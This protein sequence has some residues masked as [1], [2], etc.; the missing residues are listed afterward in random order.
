M[1][2]L[3]PN[4][5]NDKAKEQIKKAAFCRTT[6]NAKHTHTQL[7]IKKIDLKKRDL[8]TLIGCFMWSDVL[9]AHRISDIS[10]QASDRNNNDD[11]NNATK[12]H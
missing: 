10:K 5:D 8:F 6:K 7:K 3:H 12:Q 11:N 2:N 4:N 1:I 9:F